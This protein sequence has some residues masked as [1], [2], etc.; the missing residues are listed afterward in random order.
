MRGILRVPPRARLG[1][2]AGAVERTCHLIVGQYPTECLSD[3]ARVDL[4]ASELEKRGAVSATLVV[5]DDT[6]VTHRIPVK[7]DVADR[8][9]AYLEKIRMHQPITEHLPPA[10][11]DRAG[12]IGMLV[13]RKDMGQC[14]LAR[15]TFQ[16]GEQ[17]ALVRTRAADP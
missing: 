14:I 10:P 4:H 8:A 15:G 6:E 9:V 1:P 17:L 3:T 12:R 11:G 2:A 16:P 13:R 5:R 7:S